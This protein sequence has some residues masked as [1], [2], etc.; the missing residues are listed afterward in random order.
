[1]KEELVHDLIRDA[2]DIRIIIIVIVFLVQE[3]QNLTVQQY[4]EICHAIALSMV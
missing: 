2:V 4:F 1:M 3:L